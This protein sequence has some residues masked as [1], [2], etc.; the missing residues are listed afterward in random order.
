MNA[1]APMVM[2][3]AGGTGGHIFPGLAV[4]ESVRQQGGRVEW[5]GARGGMETTVVPEHGLTVHELNIAGFRGKSMVRRL[6]MPLRLLRAVWQARRVLRKT[7]P[8]SVLS[9]GGYAAAPGGLAARILGIPLF[10][11]E[12]N[13]VAGMTNR[14][15]AK[16]ARKV[17][18]GFQQ[19]AGLD[20]HYEWVGNPVRDAIHDAKD[21][22]ADSKQPF[23]I[24]VLGG[25]LGA[26]SLNKTLP[27]ALARVADNYS[28][29]VQHQCGQR[30]TDATKGAYEQTK[31]DRVKWSVMPFI[32]DM[33][34]AY[35]WADL[36]VCRAGALTIAEL[37]AAGRGAILVP[38]PFAVDDHQTT[39]AESMVAAK[40]GVLVPDAD[41]DA[42]KLAKDLSELLADRDRVVDMG[43]RARTLGKRDCAATIAQACLQGGAE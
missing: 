37:C 34:A 43:A 22:E 25:S 21:L 13:S 11:H 12:Q 29:E 1:G 16:F 33:A 30:H 4:A 17:F 28:L 35:E 3:M 5:L 14:W 7:G 24:L 26:A 2:I 8:I 42:E 38:Y 19:V 6:T 27:L 36:V 31:L 41:L 9:M 40:A 32:Q 23:K 15:L 39:N 18:T 10:V 20:D